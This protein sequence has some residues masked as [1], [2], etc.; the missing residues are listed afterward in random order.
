MT[1]MMPHVSTSTPDPEL[2]AFLFAPLWEEPNGMLLSVF[3]AFARLNLDPWYEAK[4]LAG[5]PGEA[6]IGRLG[7]LIA[8]LPDGQGARQDL[9]AIATRLVAILPREAAAAS[10]S[11]RPAHGTARSIDLW[12]LGYAAFM[13][14]ALG[15]Q[16]LSSNR[17]PPAHAMQTHQ[18]APVCVHSYATSQTVRSRQNGG[19]SAG[20]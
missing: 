16:G 3:S 7:G 18:S 9:K 4:T 5:L 13:A 1:L 15:F 8:A 19:T 12:M 2:D 10:R 14:V 11:R 6:A 17:A 20:K